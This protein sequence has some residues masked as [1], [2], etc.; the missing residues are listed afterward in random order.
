[1]INDDEIYYTPD[2]KRSTDKHE[3]TVDGTTKIY[4]NNVKVAV[5]KKSL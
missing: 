4:A 3:V 1:M 2:L 5:K